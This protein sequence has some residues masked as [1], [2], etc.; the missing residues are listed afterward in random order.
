MKLTSTWRYLSFLFE[1]EVMCGWL[2]IGGTM[3]KGVVIIILFAAFSFIFFYVFRRPSQCKQE[4]ANF[5][6]VDFLYSQLH[7]G[8]T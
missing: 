5:V 7:G 1:R 3:M 4:G 6:G 8:F 2:L